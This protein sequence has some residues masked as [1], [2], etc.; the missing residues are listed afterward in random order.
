[1][2]YKVGDR[3]KITSDKSKSG[4]WNLDGEM[5]KYLGKVMK[6]RDVGEDYYKMKEDCDE[7][8]GALIYS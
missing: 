8:G 4:F 6:I 1:M 3:V 7:R 2:K 5:D